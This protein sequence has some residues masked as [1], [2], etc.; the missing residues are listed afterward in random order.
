M[1]KHILFVIG[2]VLMVISALL[3]VFDS[4]SIPSSAYNQEEQL[5][6]DSYELLEKI[7]EQEIDE[8]L[9]A[10]YFSSYDSLNLIFSKSE[11]ASLQNIKY[12]LQN[13]EVK[14]IDN[15]LII[16]ANNGDS[17]QIKLKIPYGLNGSEI[18]ALLAD[19]ELIKNQ[20]KFNKLLLKLNIDRKLLAGD[21]IF[22]AESTAV[23]ILLSI[24]IDQS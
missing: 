24:T 12:N 22:N 16:T 3:L 23:D 15:K 19:K 11:T 20:E 10:D 7:D 18:S 2:S 6:M 21:Y 9:K 13:G 8:K 17:E 5:N 1:R 4:S 14:W